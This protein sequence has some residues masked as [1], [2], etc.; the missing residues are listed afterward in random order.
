MSDNKYKVASLDKNTK[1]VTL[2]LELESSSPF[3]KLPKKVSFEMGMDQLQKLV[4]TPAKA[5]PKKEAPAKAEP[6]KEY[7]A[8]SEDK[9]SSKKK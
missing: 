4:G 2:H 7:S 8:K 1:T 3:A 9:K 5:E 6:K